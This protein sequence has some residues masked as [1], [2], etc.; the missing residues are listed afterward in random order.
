MKALILAAGFG[1]RLAPHTDAL[2]K[3]LFPVAGRPVLERMIHRLKQAG[4]NAVA[5]NAHHLAGQIDAYLRST[6]FGVPVQVSIEPEILG[7]GGAIRRLANFW[8]AQP[9]LVVNA[10][11][12]TDID[13]AAVYAHHRR[14]GAMV[15]LV[16]HDR[17]PFNQVWVDENDRI[18]G[19]TR[20][21]DRPPA[22]CRQLAFTGIHVMD[23][24]I[25]PHI[26]AAGFSD[27]IAVY[28]RMI[29][30]GEPVHAH[31]V[32]GH[33][34]QDMGTPQG[35]REAVMTAMAPQ[36]FA[37]AFGAAPRTPIRCRQLAGDGSERTWHRLSSGDRRMIMA[38]HGITTTLAGSELNA[39][40]C[41]GRH[42]HACGLPVP[43]IYAHDDFSGLV[44]MQDLGD[45]HLQQ[46]VAG[47][48][49]ERRIAAHYRAVIDTWLDLTVKAAAGFDIA[50]TCQSAAY[51]FE[52]IMER[53]CR[54]FVEAFLN[55]YL[56][57]AVGFDALAPEF[58][59]L[60]RATLAEGAEGLIHRDLQSRNIMVHDGC[61]WLID[62]QGMR[63][64][65]VQYDLAALLIDPY[66]GLDPGLQE[67]LLDDAATAAHRRLGIDRQ[68][69]INGYR[70][71][72]VTRNLQMLGAF[73]FLSRR[74]GK[75]EFEQWIPA[76]AAMLAD[77]LRHIDRRALPGLVAV[78]DTIAAAASH[79]KPDVDDAPTANHQEKM[80]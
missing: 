48:T 13:L 33:E 67:T 26:P 56:E 78:A 46:A 11:I 79:R 42:L 24:R 73:G 32:Q 40:V 17:P 57:M 65:P 28:R 60:V 44:F 66:V 30:G 41:I 21:D 51:D 29:A 25:L 5:V 37:G 71:C 53:E 16:M 77:H 69:F 70:H 45:G 54:Y 12:V 7:T 9:F 4:C 50:W 75:H 72:A 74:R 68:R 23:A 1:T 10:D 64:G 38:D 49:D 20:Y 55:G 34:W 52:L 76:A 43:R 15:T 31:V 39:F 27:I 3:A 80:P 47:E 19:F 59:H 36:V 58:A 14:S 18:A 61:H 35:Y 63:I 22:H 62:F 6:D 8:D 2:P